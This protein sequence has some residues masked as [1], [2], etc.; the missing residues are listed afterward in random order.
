MKKAIPII[1]ASAA[2]LIMT[3]AALRP[4]PAAAVPSHDSVLA[5]YKTWKPYKQKT[6]P[7]SIKRADPA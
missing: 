4:A 6:E 7:Q 1:L 5:S 2:G 3:V